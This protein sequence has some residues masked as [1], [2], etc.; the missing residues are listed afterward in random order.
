MRILFDH[1]VFS[2]QNYGG[3]SRYFVEQIRGLQSLGQEVFLP[4][5]FFAEN[6]YLSKLQGFQ[7]KSLMPFGFKGKKWLQLQLGKTASLRALR[8]LE[9]QVFHPTYFDP[10]FL[11]EVQKRGTHWVITVHDMIHEI[12]GHGSQGFFS[13]DAR[14]VENKR[15]LAQK[16]HAVIAVSENTRRDLLHFCPEVD[17]AKVHVVY[18]GNRLKA[19][20]MELRNTH[21]PY[22]LFVGQ[23]KGYKNFKAML[24][25]LQPVLEEEKSLHVKCVGGGAFDTSELDQINSLGLEGRVQYTVIQSDAALAQ[26]YQQAECFL[27]PSLYEGFGLPVVEAM[28][29]HCP[30]LLQEGNVLREIGGESAMYFDTGN[31][32]SL[33]EALFS[34]LRSPEKRKSLIESGKKRAEYFSWEKS[35]ENHLKIYQSVAGHGIS[36]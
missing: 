32:Y 29:C 19:E 25:Q 21:A 31:K 33:P 23:R 7:Q 28:A 36:I 11:P 22:V 14:V 4:Q 1:Q 3:I 16:A 24:D 20:P 35:V 18:H 5:R 6:V 34:L 27:F 13:L 15:L 30:V 12:Y 26:T 9:P 10:Y 2:W 17:P 8:T